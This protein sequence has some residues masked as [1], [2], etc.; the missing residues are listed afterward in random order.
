VLDLPG[1]GDRSTY[2]HAANEVARHRP[3]PGINFS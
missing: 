2:R 3:G 1:R